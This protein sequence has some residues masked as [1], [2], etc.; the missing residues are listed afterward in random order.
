MPIVIPISTNIAMRHDCFADNYWVVKALHA[1]AE[2]NSFSA[3]TYDGL[4]DLLSRSDVYVKIPV[5]KISLA[6]FNFQFLNF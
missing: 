6:K 2:K 5:P 3:V 4:P 1:N